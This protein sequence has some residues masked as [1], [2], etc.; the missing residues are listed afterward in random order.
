M[1][2]IIQIFVPTE[3]GGNVG[4]WHNT[5]WGGDDNLAVQLRVNDISERNNGKFTKIRV[6]EVLLELD[7]K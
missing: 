5:N 1:K 3:P 7:C 6:L 2:Y 4:S